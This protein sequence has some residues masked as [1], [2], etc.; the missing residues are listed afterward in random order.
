MDSK[1]PLR[2]PTGTF[3][4]NRG[5]DASAEKE[6][7][8]PSGA[9]DM[10]YEYVRGDQKASPMLSTTTMHTYKKKCSELRMMKHFFEN[11]KNFA[12]VPQIE[13]DTAKK[14]GDSAVI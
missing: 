10:V 13:V 5:A 4:A 14:K 8:L 12:T 7:S 2:S 9:I 11:Y 1:Y 3:A 6:A